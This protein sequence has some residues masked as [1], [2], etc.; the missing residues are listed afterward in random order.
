MFIQQDDHSKNMAIQLIG[1]DK[2]IFDVSKF[3]KNCNLSQN[4]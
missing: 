2:E 1:D 4:F 3:I